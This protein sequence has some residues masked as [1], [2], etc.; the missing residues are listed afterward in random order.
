VKPTIIYNPNEFNNIN[1]SYLWSLWREQ[2]DLVP[3]VEYV[4]GYDKKYTL[5]ASSFLHNNEWYKS[6]TGRGYRWLQDHLWDSGVNELSEASDSTLVLRARDWVYITQSLWYQEFGYDQIEYAPSYEK[7]FLMLL[8]I[9]KP[10]RDNLVIAAD[11][12][13][14]DSLYSYV[15]HGVYLDND[16]DRT[17]PLYANL[18]NPDWYSKTCF[19][20][21]AETK[22]DTDLFISEKSFK[23]L[24]MFHPTIIYSTPNTLS[25]LHTLGFETFD[26]IID[27]SYDN[28]PDEYVRLGKIVVEVGKLYLMYKQGM[29]FRDAITQQKL[30]H[31]HNR[32][33]DFAHVKQLFKEQIADQVME[34]IG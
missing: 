24:A 10:H 18:I 31:N 12:F 25:Y 14:N 9:S 15:D 11:Q 34:Y 27:E 28:E 8:R 4:S 1:C 30:M 13:L 19:S 33:Y 23:P 17:S 21:T 22:V 29:L 6:W 32:F 26:H 5:I 3:Q 16:F 2:F 20:L 7:F